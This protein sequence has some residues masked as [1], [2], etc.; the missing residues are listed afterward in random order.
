[1]ITINGIQSGDARAVW[2][3]VEQWMADACEY[4][5]GLIEP[6]H[7]LAEIERAERQLWVIC[8]DGL[9]TA[10]ATTRIDVHPTGIRVLSVPTLGGRSMDAWLGP[11]VDTLR[12]YGR[13]QGCAGMEA[14]GRR[15]WA[16][17]LR[18]HGWIERCITVATEI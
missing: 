3:I 18:K 6:G 7:I 15:G 13:E 1:M 17:A 2:P 14:S 10:A 9:P 8:I 4:A 11:W 5:D 12:R 16:R